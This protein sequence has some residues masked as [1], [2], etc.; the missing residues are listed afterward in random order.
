[1]SV[2]LPPLTLRRG[3]RTTLESWVRAGTIEARMAQ[4]A[5]IVLLAAEG[6][7]NADIAEVVGLHYNQVG[8]WRGWRPSV[9][10]N[11]S[12]RKLLDHVTQQL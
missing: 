12:G 5:R 1:M 11:G 7:S 4:R 9:G 10:V 8:L 6:M 2:R 3:D